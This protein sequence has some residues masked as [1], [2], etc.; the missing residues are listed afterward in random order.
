MLTHF[1]LFSAVIIP[2]SLISLAIAAYGASALSLYISVAVPIYNLPFETATSFKPVAL[3][4][5]EEVVDV[6]GTEEL[7]DELE[8]VG[9]TGFYR[10]LL[11][12]VQLLRRM[13]LTVS[14]RHCEY[15]SFWYLQ[16]HPVAQVVPPL[17]PIPP[18]SNHLGISS[19]IKLIV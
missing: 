1:I 19:R 17:Q 4:G 7:L 10:S 14:W 2:N 3:G 9:V 15:Q 6:G 8:G 18:P 16:T 5:V 13:A 11:S 12:N